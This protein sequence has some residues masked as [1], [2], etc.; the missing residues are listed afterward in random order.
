MMTE[1]EEV[2][3]VIASDA[4][5]VLHRRLAEVSGPRCQVCV[6]RERFLGTLVSRDDEANLMVATAFLR[7]SPPDWRHA[8][9]DDMRCLLEDPMGYIASTLLKAGV[10]STVPLEFGH[11]ASRA[12]TE[13]RIT[14]GPT[15][16][17]LTVIVLDDAI[18]FMV[19][20][21]PTATDAPP[22]HP[23]AIALT[24]RI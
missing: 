14:D 13:Y 23:R 21:I 5:G 9:R 19:G 2:V 11:A 15:D 7:L 4:L 1:Y 10:T 20:F 6:A 17:T 16:L 18:Q 24:G 22:T 3:K 12:L 8:H